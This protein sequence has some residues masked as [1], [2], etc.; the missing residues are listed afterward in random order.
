MI[1]IHKVIDLRTEDIPKIEALFSKDFARDILIIIDEAESYLK[2]LRS[3]KEESVKVLE[4]I[5]R[6]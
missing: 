6:K 5:Q 2:L 1:P 3:T 4:L